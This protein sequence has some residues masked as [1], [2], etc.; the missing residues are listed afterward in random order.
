MT[1]KNLLNKDIL[2]NER[3]NSSFLSINHQNLNLNCKIFFGNFFLDSFNYFPMTNQNQ[4]FSELYSWREK[5]NYEIFYTKNFYSQFENNKKNY[6]KI[7]DCFVLGSSPADN[8][9]RNIITFLPRIFF[10]HEKEINL[11]IHRNSTNKFRDFLE[12]LLS[13]M[14]KNIKKFIYLDDDFYYFENS[15][16]PQYLN[17]SISIKILNQLLSK[18]NKENRKIYITRKNSTYRKIIN[19][20]DLIDEL[21]LKNFDIADTTNM[22]INEQIEIFSS[23]NTIVSPT[24]SALTNLVFCKPGTKVLE[25]RPRYNYA[26]EN[27][28]KNRFLEVC[29]QLNLEYSSID[30]DPVISKDV[31]KNLNKFINPEIVNQS[32]YYKNL[33]VKLNDFKLIADD[34]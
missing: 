23:A 28:L 8:Y 2:N 4:T 3:I 10:I 24:S 32:N 13:F 16:I 29:N 25:I 6:K 7:K 1:L 20:T 9:Y 21:K 18:K 12:Q 17:K 26:Y 19:E 22:S 27:I 14:G 34:L 5:H 31:N 11:A 15:K 30:A 33:L